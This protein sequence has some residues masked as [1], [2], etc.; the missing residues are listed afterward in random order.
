MITWLFSDPRKPREK[1]EGGAGKGE[2]KDRSGQV[3]FRVLR[4]LL[5]GG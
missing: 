5:G 3:G 1:A 4:V 2:A